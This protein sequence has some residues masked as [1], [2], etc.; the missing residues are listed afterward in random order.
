MAR[1]LN[2]HDRAFRAAFDECEQHLHSHLDWSPH[3]QL[4][5]D[6]TAARMD[7]EAVVQPLLFAI[8]V[9]LAAVWRERGVRPE[10]VVG[11]SMGEVAAAYVAGVLNLADTAELTSV[12]AQ[13][14]ADLVTQ[15]SS[16][17]AMAVVGL[18]YA[19]RPA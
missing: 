7:E 19:T 4:H 11:H 16:R 14:L 12:R 2:A 18:H 6:G 5:A 9:A 13:L 3:D 1:G 8:Q 10:A 15:L 17:G